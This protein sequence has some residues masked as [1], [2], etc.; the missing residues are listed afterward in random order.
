MV[1]AYPA[2]TVGIAP[3]LLRQAIQ[4]GLDLGKI[5]DHSVLAVADAA[6]CALG[7]KHT[8]TRPGVL[9]K[10]GVYHKPE[11]IYMEAFRTVFTLRYLEAFP[12]RTPYELVAARCGDIF[13]ALSASFRLGIDISLYLDYTGVGIGVAEIVQKHLRE[14]PGTASQ[15]RIRPI[16]LTGGKAEY[17]PG[18]TTCSKYALVSNMLKLMG[19]QEPEL[20]IPATLEEMVATLDEL[21]AYQEHLSRETGYASY[22]GKAGFHDDRVIALGLSVLPP[23][24]RPIYSKRVY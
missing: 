20:L 3:R 12:L 21:R 24:P 9:D 6:T 4:C 16:T 15:V 7:M 10:Q 18:Q 5:Q 13:E 1:S 14:R 22:D 11:P 23:F 2:P 8:R 19:A 17:R